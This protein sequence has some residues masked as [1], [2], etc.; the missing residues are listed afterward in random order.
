MNRKL[1]QGLAA[2]SGIAAAALVGASM[3]FW[4]TP[5]GVNNYINKI[6]LL[7]LLR[8]PNRSPRWG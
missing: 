2:L 1:K 6:T 3:W 5:V 8:S 7:S 4:F